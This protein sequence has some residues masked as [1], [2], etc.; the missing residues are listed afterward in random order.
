MEAALEMELEMQDV[1]PSPLQSPVPFTSRLGQGGV[2]GGGGGTSSGSITS[3]SGS[4][5]DAGF[6]LR[7]LQESYH[8]HAHTHG[9]AQPSNSRT[10]SVFLLLNSMI[11]SGVFNIPHVFSRA[12]L[13]T[14]YILLTVS[15]LLVYLGLIVLVQVGEF[16]PELH[17]YSALARH[18][19]SGS[20]TAARSVDFFIAIIGFGSLMS[21]ISAILSMVQGLGQSWAGDSSTASTTTTTTCLILLLLVFPLCLTRH[22]GH[23]SFISV[24]SMASVF[25]VLCLVVIGGPPYSAEYGGPGTNTPP[26]LF[27]PSASSI[28]QLGS[29]I[30][31]FACASATFHTFRFMKTKTVDEWRVVCRWTVFCG[32]AL[33]V[34]MGT[35]GYC[36]FGQDTDGIILANF[37]QGHVG[38]AFQMLFILHLVL[39]IPLDFLVA[40][41]SL[42]RICGVE[43]G[44]L[45]GNA[46]HALFTLALLAFFSFV[47]FLLDA[48]GLG[49]GDAFSTILNFTG[50][51]GGSVISFVLP[52]AM[53]LRQR[54]Q[55]STNFVLEL[56]PC[57]VML[58][59]GLVVAVYVPVTTVLHAVKS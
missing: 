56:L 12:G 24:V 51:L 29:V 52:A 28:R 5:A 48:A 16:H 40:R 2:G 20:T 33:C 18:V 32:W 35:A 26:T 37:T 59:V 49:S 14:S 22:Y 55:H 38:D 27:A 3:A 34:A 57:A 43:G 50:G 36:A 39:Y 19:F 46:Q 4:V 45:A 58:V 17:D 21:Y 13:L 42:L 44:A 47:V 15:A 6:G 8:P 23:F 7:K 25:S 10:Y 11:G 1:I 53:F 30:F 31:T 9:H 54:Y 41:H